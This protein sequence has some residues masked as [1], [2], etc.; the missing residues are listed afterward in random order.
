MIH[1][2]TKLHLPLLS[3]TSG[4]IFYLFTSLEKPRQQE[5]IVFQV[6]SFYF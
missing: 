2:T 3:Q 5:K 4:H 1:R 6:F